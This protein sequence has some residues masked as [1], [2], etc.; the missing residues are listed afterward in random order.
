MMRALL[1]VAALALG[2]AAAQCPT[3]T[4]DPFARCT[5]GIPNLHAVTAPGRPT[6][7]R[8]GQ[9]TPAGWQYL[10]D[11]LHVTDVVML[12]DAIES[13]GQAEDQPARDLGLHVAV[14]TMPPVDYGWDFR[15]PAQLLEGPT[16]RQA[17]EAVA[18]I[19]RASGPVY[20]HCSH[21]RDRTGLVVGLYRVFVD[22]LSPDLAYA[23]MVATGFRPINH[24]LHEVWEQLFIDGSPRERAVRQASFRAF[25][26]F[27]TPPEVSHHAR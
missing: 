19:V 11:T 3:D 20:V 7:Y 25:L 10:R 9:P 16:P 21:G 17:A 15:T 24:G 1:L 8:G 4:V 27:A 6:F 14:H 13:H 26:T 12:D 18:A 22:G 2:C 23:E 5:E